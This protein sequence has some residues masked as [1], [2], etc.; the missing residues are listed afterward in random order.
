MFDAIRNNKRIVQIFLLLI[1]IPFA[2]WGLEAYFQGGGSD[3]LVRIGRTRI[4]LNQYREALRNEQDRL[5][6]ENPGMNPANFD[7]EALRD[8]VLDGL[9]NR[10]LLLLEA[11]KRGLNVRLAMQQLIAQ[12]P[13][14]H[15]NGAFSQTAYES[16]LAAN[17]RTVSE[18]EA[19]LQEQLLRRPLL[20]A[21]LD[22]SFTP[23]TV[24]DRI[25]TLQTETRD[26]QESLITS[27]SLAGKVEVTDAE[28]KQFYEDNSALFSHPEQIQVEYVVLSQEL[29]D[30][31]VKFSEAEI[32]AWYESHRDLFVKKQEERR[33]SHILL[34][35]DEGV[36]KEKVRAKALQLLAE[37][38]KAPGNFAKLAQE[39][40]QDPGSAEQGGDLG[41]FLPRQV[42]DKSFADAAFALKKGEI[43]DLAESSFGFHIIRAD[44]IRPGEYLSFAEARSQVERAMREQ[45]AVRLFAEAAENFRNLVFDEPDLKAAASAYGLPIQ[46]SGWLNRESRGQELIHNPQLIRTMFSDEVLKNGRNTEVV[47]VAPGTLA[48][49]RLLNLEPAR[50]LPFDEVKQAIAAGLRGEKAQALAVEQGEAKLAELQEKEARVNWGKNQTVSRL[51][52]DQLHPAALKAILKVKTDKLPAYAGVALPGQGYA[53]YRINKADTPPVE[54]ELARALARQ[55]EQFIAQN[56]TMAYLAAL[57]QRYK[58]KVN[59]NLIRDKEQ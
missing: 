15:E 12:I 23:K 8:M 26:V 13:D 50:L 6:R 32:R 46:K 2:V 49:A 9:I 17:R 56:E 1:T 54:P 27:A 48:A 11:Q 29:L 20:S 59:D 14:F 39:H 44:D 58:V 4:G 55:V 38:K 35:T 43:S 25:V 33:L 16:A 21:V 7:S 52:P 57:R 40:S 30:S 45:N 37:V 36:D 34:A 31:M 19:D 47:E 18:F 24:T 53:L 10:H 51:F 41:E 28:I 22:A 42:F 5:K 3:D